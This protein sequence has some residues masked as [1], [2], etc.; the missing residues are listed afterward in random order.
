MHIRN[1]P[2]YSPG[3]SIIQ[4]KL[5]LQW[6]PEQISDRLKRLYGSKSVCHEV[7]YNYVGEDKLRER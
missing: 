6:S 3:D 1:L 4:E 7:I 5:K 2:T